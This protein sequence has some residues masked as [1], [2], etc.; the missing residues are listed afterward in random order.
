MNDVTSVIDTHQTGHRMIV[1]RALTCAQVRDVD[2]R[3]IDDYGMTGLVLMENAGRNAAELLRSIGISGRVVA[4]C[5]KGN[6]GGDG[7]VIARHLEKAGVD[8]RVLLCVPPDSLTGDAAA[9]FQILQ[10]AQTPI[11][12]PP[13]DWNTELGKVDW[14]VDALLGTG[15]QGA[16]REPFVSAVKAINS[17]VA[18]V[19]AV[20]VPSGLD[21]DTG[22]PLCDQRS[23]VDAQPQAENPLRD[24]VCVRADHTVTFVA[25]KAGFDLPGASEWTG[26]VHVADIGV[27][28]KLLSDF[29]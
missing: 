6:N 5:G 27:P 23:E 25:R 24:D 14:I 11:A 16:L 12:V 26:R 17:A 7:F 29:R 8:V 2:R 4:C 9:N 20:D 18:K 10:R 13:I 15:S 22:R 19:F 21:C 3:A 28:L 1:P